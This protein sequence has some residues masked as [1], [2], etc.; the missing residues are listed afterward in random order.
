MVS[1]TK[2]G[3][4]L[5]R[6][7][8]VAGIFILAVLTTLGT[9]GGGGDGGS[10]VPSNPLVIT[11]SNAVDVAE[12]AGSVVTLAAIPGDYG[13]LPYGISV[14]PQNKMQSRLRAVFVHA[15]STMNNIA[16]TDAAG[17]PQGLHV[18]IEEQCDTGSVAIVWDDA[19]DN[20]LLSGGESLQLTFN[21][22][23]D[24]MAGIT[25]NGR[26]TLRVNSI[27]GDPQNDAADWSVSVTLTDENASYEDADGK[28]TFNG[29]MTMTVTNNATA[30]TQLLKLEGTSYTVTSNSDVASLTNFMFSTLL[31]LALGTYEIDADYTLADSQLGG[32]IT[33]VTNPVF[34]GVYDV[35]LDVVEN[36]T[37]GKMTI[38]GAGGSAVTIEPYDDLNAL[39]S[40][41]ANGDGTF[42][43]TWQVAWLN[44]E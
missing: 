27:T 40:L 10:N 41:D 15:K 6:G 35:G 26:T 33:V 28:F 31:N 14:A 11:S 42:E 21:N 38:T 22:C 7:L 24:A 17:L 39:V 1:S 18:E 25:L 44:L 2:A 12:D 16:P 32:V 4:H 29:S 20:N 13:S 30:S 9:G 5:L 34:S 3:S 36:P 8:G 19:N 37:A 43:N 23:H